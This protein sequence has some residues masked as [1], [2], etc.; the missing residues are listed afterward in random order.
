MIDFVVVIGFVAVFPGYP[1]EER[2]GAVNQS[3]PDGELAPIVEEDARET[4][5]T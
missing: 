4:R 2:G 3:P 5:Q 1:S